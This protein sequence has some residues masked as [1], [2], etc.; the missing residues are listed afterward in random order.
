VKYFLGVLF[1]IMINSN[2]LAQL[3]SERILFSLDKEQTDG[4]LLAVEHYKKNYSS[5]AYGLTMI[6][7]GTNLVFLFVK[8]PGQKWGRGG[9]SVMVKIIYS[10]ELSKIIKVSQTGTR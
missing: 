1:F 2:C 8:D 10:K 6:D 4:M 3:S 7:N 5:E 9:G